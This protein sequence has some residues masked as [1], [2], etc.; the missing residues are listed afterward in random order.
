VITTVSTQPP[1]AKE[2]PPPC[3]DQPLDGSGFAADSWSLPAELVAQLDT[4]VGRHFQR[5]DII[6]HADPRPTDIGN[7]ELSRRRAEAVSE[8]L[9]RR[10]IEADVVKATGVGASQPAGPSDTP[11]DYARDRRV[12]LRA[13]CA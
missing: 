6:G 9:A 4:I 13:W 12:E 11:A 8:E 10:H 1:A 7:D 2:L 3:V 5:I